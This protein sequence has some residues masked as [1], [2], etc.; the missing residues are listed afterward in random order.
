MPGCFNH[1]ASSSSVI[2]LKYKINEQLPG[3]IKYSARYSKLD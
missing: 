2:K 3:C 1:T